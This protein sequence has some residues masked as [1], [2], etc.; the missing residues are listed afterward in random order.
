MR[1]RAP[2][3]A[4]ALFWSA[5]ARAEVID[6]FEA[7]SAPTPW[8]FSN[9]GEFPGA[10][11]SLTTGTGHTGKGAHVAYD[12]TGGGAYVAFGRA[13]PNVAAGRPLAFWL[14]ADPRAKLGVRLNDSNGQ[15]LQYDLRLPF[16]AALGGEWCRMVLPAAATPGDHWGGD[17]DGVVHGPLT[18]VWIVVAKP[19]YAPAAGSVDVDDVA[20]VDPAVFEIDP[21][22]TTAPLAGGDLFSRWGAAIHSTSD[23]KT[24]DALHAAGLTWARTDLFWDW[25]EKTPGVYDFAAFDGLVSALEARGMK[26]VLILDY[27]NPLYGGGPPKTQV[28]ID[29]YGAYAEAAAR[30]FAGRP[31]VFEVWN[32]PDNQFWPPGNVPLEYAAALPA[33]ISAVHRG[34]SKALV[35]TGGVSWFFWDFFDKVLAAGA[36]EG[37]D[38]VGVHPYR[39]EWPETAVGDFIRLRKTVGEHVLANPPVIDTEW[40]YTATDLGGDGQKAGPRARQAVLAVRQ[41]LTLWAASVPVAIWYDARDDCVDGANGECNFGLLANDGSDKPAIEAV[42]AL[43]DAARGR[44]LTALLS[45]PET[46]RALRLEGADDVIVVAW[47]S[48]PG[49]SVDTSAPVP[50]RATD[51]FGAPLTVTASGGNVTFTLKETDGPVYLQYARPPGFDGG[52][53]ADAAAPTSDGAVRADSGGGHAGADVAAP[54]GEPD[55]G[56]APTADQG[57]SGGCGCTTGGRGRDGLALF[58]LLGVLSAGR[59]RKR[60]DLR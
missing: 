17:N 55:G 16:E 3:L 50:L 30:H 35:S 7:A 21:F 6:D 25:V 47:A 54:G 60:G 5:Y 15:T 46:A 59:K 43:A 29:A 33:A 23:T 38:F 34:D 39:G 40:G 9:G 28:A 37:A 10:T 13:L 2:L 58:V 32:E 44:T 57:A 36:A 12:F 51:L 48:E 20:F 26:A 19:S 1:R 8:Q 49:Q 14:R 24:L 45:T 56:A 53:P 41:Q 31:V 52:T 22:A 11:G 4:L 27:G 42:R 18:N